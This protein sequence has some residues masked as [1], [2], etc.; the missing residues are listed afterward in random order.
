MQPDRALAHKIL[1]EIMLGVE[2]DFATGLETL[3]VAL[4]GAFYL[5]AFML[6]LR[7]EE[8]PLIELRDIN[9]H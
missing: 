4:E 2:Q 5:I 7:G 6:A 9:S 3:H 8:M 1:K